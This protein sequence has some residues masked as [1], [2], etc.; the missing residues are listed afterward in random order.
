[1]KVIFAVIIF[2]I[3]VFVSNLQAQIKSGKK[4]APQ[5]SNLKKRRR[6][7]ISV[8]VINGKAIK[9]VKPVFPRAAMA[10]NARGAVKVQ[11][12]IDKKGQIIEA[13]ATSGHP[14]LHANS[15][16]AAFASAFEPVIINGKP[17]NVS[18]VIVYNY[19]A[20]FFN[21]LEIGNSFGSG[22]LLEMLPL[23]FE[24]EKLLY[25]Q[26]QTEGFNKDSATFQ[27]TLEAFE[28][29]LFTDKKNLWLF[30]TGIL[31]NKIQFGFPKKE[32][33]INNLRNYISDSPT[34]LSP[35]LIT[36]LKKLL[37]LA[38]NPQLNTYD[39]QTSDNFYEQMNEIN[40]K[41]FLLGN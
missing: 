1:M 10:I 26:Y 8:G 27:K 29:K 32:I 9:L 17:I 24:D 41:M 31:L 3:F 28:K 38:E 21:W 36:R 25:K 2:I 14:V 15:I 40:E 6:E 11:V 23:G 37:N 22:N 12:L 20:D 7:A 16:T 35:A 34:D 5:S 4:P 30:Q 39:S 33:D 19:T 18:G 13:K